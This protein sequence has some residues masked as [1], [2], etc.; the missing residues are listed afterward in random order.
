MGLQ[1]QGKSIILQVLHNVHDA[2][3]NPPKKRVTRKLTGF[4]KSIITV[5]VNFFP[6]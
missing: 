6:V 5:H 3:N 4:L 2:K 1:I